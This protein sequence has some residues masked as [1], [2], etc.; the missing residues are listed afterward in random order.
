MTIATTGTQRSVYQY[1]TSHDVS[2]YAGSENDDDSNKLFKTK[3]IM[4]SFAL[5]P[6]HIREKE[7]ERA[8]VREFRTISP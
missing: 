4:K 5:C 3:K 6:S 8:C 1:A 2:V 7:I